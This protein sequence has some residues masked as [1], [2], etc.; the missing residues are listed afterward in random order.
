M[1]LAVVTA[2]VLASAMQAGSAS[3]APDLRPDPPPA[4]DAPATQ[5]AAEPAARAWVT[6]VDEQRWEESWRAA[7]TLFQSRVSSSEW[8][9][10]VQPVRQPLGAVT[11]RALEG[12]TR[13]TSLPGAPD[14]DYELIAFRTSFAAKPDAIEMVVL[15]R[16]SSGW[17]VAG[18]FIQ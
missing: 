9:S 14:G 17:K 7:A 4:T 12:F 10:T 5:T 15:A 3:D 1:I 18:Y 6:L 11:A 8:A 13:T 16:D 2:V